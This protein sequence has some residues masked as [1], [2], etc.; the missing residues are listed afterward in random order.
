MAKLLQGT[1]MNKNP[2]MAQM[3]LASPDYT[4][5][6]R[7]QGGEPI[8]CWV[9]MDGEDRGGVRTTAA[10]PHIAS[11]TK[12]MGA[13]AKEKLLELRAGEKKEPQLLNHSQHE[14]EE[15]GG[16]CAWHSVTFGV[17]SDTGAKDLLCSK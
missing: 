3:D 10:S 7:L 1:K 9:V 15:V 11:I 12:K 13:K 17:I 6:P 16:K 14:G 2:K 8:C 4:G 5:Q